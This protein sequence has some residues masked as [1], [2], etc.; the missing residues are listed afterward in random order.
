MLPD[1]DYL[2]TEATEF[3]EVLLVASARGLN[4]VLPLLG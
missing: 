2:P 4:L 1:S 3:D